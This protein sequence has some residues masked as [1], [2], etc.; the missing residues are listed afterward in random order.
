[1]NLYYYGE[2][3]KPLFFIEVKPKEYMTL[4]S[5]SIRSFHCFC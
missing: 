5:L 4:T 1:M 3:Q 2:E